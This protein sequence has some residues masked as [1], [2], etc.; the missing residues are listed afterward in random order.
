MTTQ[1]LYVCTCVFVCVY[2]IQWALLLFL[3]LSL[4]LI[5]MLF[6]LCWYLSAG[7]IFL[8]AVENVSQFVCMCSTACAISTQPCAYNSSLTTIW[9]V[10]V[11]CSKQY[12]WNQKFEI[13]KYTSL[14]ASAHLRLTCRVHVQSFTS[15]RTSKFLLWIYL[16]DYPQTFINCSP[17]YSL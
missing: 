17:R 3:V 9:V 5:L 14:Q 4:C 8:D 1:L 16:V 6:V 15:K 11:C 13:E 10:L 2:I 7:Q 12:I